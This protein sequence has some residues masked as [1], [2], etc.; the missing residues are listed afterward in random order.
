MRTQSA[1]PID[2]LSAARD[3]YGRVLAV[4]GPTNTGKT[5]L[6]VERMLG[7]RTGVIGLPLRLLAREIYDRVVA[8][9]GANIV[10]LVTG[11]EKIIPDR[12]AYFV[13]TVES[14]P[15]E[16]SFAFVAIDEIQLA[17]DPER[18]HV[19][20]DR[21]LH[22]RGTQETMFLGAETI[23]PV[24]RQLLPGIEFLS[25]PRLST[26]RFDGPR[27]LSRLRRRSAVV[28]FSAEDVYA[29]AEQVRRYRGG[30]AVVLGALSP[31]TRNAQ[32]AMFE[33]G[34]VDYMVATDAVGMGL[35]LHLDHVAFAG[36]RK[37]D[38]FAPRALT[39][40]ELGQIAGR[41]GRYLSDGTFGTTAT[42]SE[43]DPE[44]VERIE[45]H[46]FD[47]VKGVYWRNSDL[48]FSS[49]GA[50]LRSLDEPPPIE[51]RK[52][53][54]RP[55]RATDQ[56]AFM[57]LVESRSVQG[58]NAVRLLWD[59]C[60]IPDYDK[61]LTESHSRL[62]GRVFDFLT[63]PEGELPTGWLAGQIARL[64]R[65][66]GDI[67]AL[68]ARI[69]QVRTWTYV[70][71]HAGWVR[72]AVH[73]QSRAREVEDRLS[74][75]LHE[76][77]T[78]RFVDRRSAALTRRLGNT[79]EM[80]CTVTATGQV[81]VEGHLIGRLEGFRFV[82]DT[83]H[84]GE[85]R[86]LLTAAQRSLRRELNVRAGKLLADGESSLAVDDTSILWR[87]DAVARLGAGTAPAAPKI[88]LI[89][90]DLLD[91]TVRR[92]IEAKLAQFL[93]SYLD[94]VLSPLRAI[95]APGLTG[96]SRGLVF[97]L[98]E[99]MGT[100]TRGAVLEQIEAL[101]PAERR[102]LRRRGVRIGAAT[103]Y[104]PSLVRPRRASVNGW[105]WAI[106]NGVVPLPVAPRPGAVS[107]RVA[108]DLPEGF[109]RACGYVV[110]GERA[111]RVDMA[112]RLAL[113][114]HS[115]AEAGPVAPSAELM[116]TVGCGG[117]AFAGVMVALGFARV[118]NEGRFA[119][120]PARRAAARR[121]RA[122]QRVNDQSP[123]AVLA[124]FPVPRGK[125]GA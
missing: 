112:E 110:L 28:G 75:A 21:L 52:L 29:M 42:C 49:P 95:A 41:A 24:L 83:S 108:P 6:A 124:R 111:V 38:G 117:E 63:G 12:A 10:A 91:G 17:A 57:A 115:A 59:V 113:A 33:A 84:G 85:V 90:G 92:E 104:V 66:E 118:G 105:L 47:A 94:E 107:V 8:A 61:T 53:V 64:D 102:E 39:A 72:D 69:A 23:R 56:A 77:L 60:Q 88:A 1:P 114:V 9:R 54:M 76:R 35:N 7:H 67:D 27:K 44:L 101:S 100:I 2:N 46:R 16:R 82:A 80:Y 125:A 50:L 74:D 99:A 40:S 121:Q 93:D 96:A 4:L 26:L 89:G 120:A 48:E 58:R 119:R 14:M 79:D 3:G 37:F 103:V 34:E 51:W 70:C 15:L 86:L 5:H 19:F 25:R 78:Q 30:A 36:V 71:H 32:V 62:L 45:N 122:P 13:C 55:R 87:G 20:T 18:G 22:A 68:S 65:T 11:E 31:R 73:W 109:L 123:F 43:L 116:A 98:G 106:Y 97:Q 81:E